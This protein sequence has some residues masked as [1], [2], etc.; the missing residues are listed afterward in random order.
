[1][2][3]FWFLT[4][5]NF[6]DFSQHIIQTRKHTIN[7]L[8]SDHCAYQWVFNIFN[9][10]VKHYCAQECVFYVH[11]YS[12]SSYVF[13]QSERDTQW[14]FECARLSSADGHATYPVWPHCQMLVNRSD[15]ETDDSWY[16]SHPDSFGPAQWRFRD[17]GHTKTYGAIQS[18][19]GSHGERQESGFACGNGKGRWPIKQYPSKV[20]YFHESAFYQSD[21]KPWWQSYIFVVAITED[22]VTQ[23]NMSDQHNTLIFCCFDKYWFFGAFSFIFSYYY[24]EDC[25]WCTQLLLS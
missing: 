2:P 5:T 16:F 20:S 21:T 24:S 23:L 25:V 13:S 7:T 19:A 3:F 14:T 4:F 10:F 6:I 8:Y 1:M 9:I 11:Q 15:W 18:R 12:V 22:I 17:R